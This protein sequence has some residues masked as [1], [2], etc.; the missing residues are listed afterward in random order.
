MSRKKRG[1]VVEVEC[2]VFKRLLAF[3]ID[4]LILDI[5]VFSPLKELVYRI[6]PKDMT[7]TESS[8]FLNSNPAMFQSLYVVFIFMFVLMIIYFTIME[9]K[10]HQTIGKMFLGIYIKSSTKLELSFWR[11]LF[12]NITFLPVFPV[13]ILWIIDPLYVLF[14]NKRFMEKLSNISLIEQKVL[15]P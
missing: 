1:K 12:S 8:Q 14:T 9:F 11:V 4:V 10:F 7:Y 5:I 15:E 13:I 6:V 2:S 3:I